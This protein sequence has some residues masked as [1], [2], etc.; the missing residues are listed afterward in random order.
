MNLVGRRSGHTPGILIY[1]DIIQSAGLSCDTWF[2]RNTESVLVCRL[3][4]LLLFFVVL[5]P[6]S[7]IATLC[8]TSR[9]S[10][11]CCCIH[12]DLLAVIRKAGPCL[13]CSPSFLF[14][15]GLNLDFL[16]LL[17]SVCFILLFLFVFILPFF[18][19]RRQKVFL[20]RLE[21]FFEFV[22]SNLA[23]THSERGKDGHTEIV[24]CKAE[25]FSNLIT[26]RYRIFPWDRYGF[27]TRSLVDWWVSSWLARVYYF[28]RL[29]RN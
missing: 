29:C 5:P 25:S 9:G 18:F 4:Q 3:Y 23:A 8:S 13:S 24:G 11:S 6:V 20:P 1:I 14:V 12:F 28:F 26:I 10:A 17:P 16:L 2:I 19:S 21:P 27:L 7:G 15:S 22:Q